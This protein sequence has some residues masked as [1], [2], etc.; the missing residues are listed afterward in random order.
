MKY[1]F[2]VPVHNSEKYLN[3]CINSLLNQT[4][5]N[6]EIIVIIN[7]CTDG[8]EKIVLDF[9]KYNDKIIV[10]KTDVVGVGKVRNLGIKKSTGDY[11]IT[12]DSDDYINI[13]TLKT[14]NNNLLKYDQA[15]IIR[16]NA[17]YKQRGNK[18]N[19]FQTEKTSGFYTGEN[20]II[21]FITEF[22]NQNKIFGP[23]WLYA[24]NKN[25]FLKK[26]YKFSDKFQEDFGLIPIMIINAKTVIVIKEVLYY[27]VFHEK[28][29]TNNEKNRWRKAIDVL[30][31][32]DNHVK[33]ISESTY[34]NEIKKKYIDYLNMTLIRKLIKLNN[35]ERQLYK[36]E[37]NKRGVTIE[38]Y[39]DNYTDI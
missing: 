7:N 21:D 19:M 24:I 29:I 32:Y 2:I 28:S 33:F 31:H 1:S 25:Y 26:K 12:V 6:F 22:L 16:F 34:S 4:Y 37:I 15:E 17:K 36:E 38:D 27:Y 8:S 3:K 18:D 5:A 13:N 10:L 23:S 30:Y 20:C 35:E 9:A 39:I 11:F 14:I